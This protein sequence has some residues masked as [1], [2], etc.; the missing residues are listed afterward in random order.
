MKWLARLRHDWTNNDG[1]PWE[2]W[3]PGPDLKDRVL[4]ALAVALHVVLIGALVWMMVR[5]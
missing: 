1:K 5:S 2:Q 3:E 4:V